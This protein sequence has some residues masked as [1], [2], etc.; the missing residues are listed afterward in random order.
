MCKISLPWQGVSP[1]PLSLPVSADHV[2]LLSWLWGLSVSSEDSTLILCSCA[3]DLYRPLWCAGQHS[4]YKTT[5]CLSS[6]LNANV[7]LLIQ[8]LSL[9]IMRSDNTCMSST[10]LSVVVPYWYARLHT[11]TKTLESAHFRVCNRYQKDPTM[12]ISILLFH[13]VFWYWAAI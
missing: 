9:N 1:T 4:C 10:L 3:P 5:D 12:L 6:S 13:V 8:M 7:G 2:C 11:F